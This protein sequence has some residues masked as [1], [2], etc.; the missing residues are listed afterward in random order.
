MPETEIG[1]ARQPSAMQFRL[2]VLRHHR[3]VYRVCYS[4]LRDQHEAEDAAQDAFMRYWQRGGGVRGA[5]AWLITVARNVCLD[6]LRRSQRLNETA[7]L[8]PDQEAGEGDAEGQAEQE[9]S[10]GLLSNLVEQLPE[11]QRSLILLFDV[12]G[13][14]GAE[15]AEAL[16]LNTN[17]VKVYLHRARKTLRREMERLHE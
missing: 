11:P 5:K 1:E 12:H 6:R 17:Q 14:S 10:M 13:L 8:E 4:L 9:Q 7:L 16:E 2:A 15:C 3:L